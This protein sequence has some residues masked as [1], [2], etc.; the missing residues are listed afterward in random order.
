MYRHDLAM[1]EKANEER[2]EGVP[3]PV[4]TMP[5]YGDPTPSACPPRGGSGGLIPTC[6]H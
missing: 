4:R 5:D 2:D 6:F 1:A 3:A